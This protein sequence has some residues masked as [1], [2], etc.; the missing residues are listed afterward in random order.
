MIPIH[1]RVQICSLPEILRLICI[2]FYYLRRGETYVGTFFRGTF[3]AWP[4]ARDHVNLQV[5]LKV[6][7]RASALAKKNGP[8]ILRLEL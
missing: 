3:A 1:G 6:S 4:R 8:A 5:V 7:S 2:A